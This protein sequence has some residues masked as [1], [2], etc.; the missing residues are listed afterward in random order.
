M[1]T[2]A[3]RIQRGPIPVA[4]ALG[5][6]K[7]IA[8]GLE[9]AHEKGV[10]HRDLKPANIKITADGKV[11]VLDF[12]L[13]KAYEATPAVDISNSPTLVSAASMPG[14]ILGTAA[15][16]SPEQARGKNVD[17]R[18]DVFSFGCVLYEMLT[19]Q[20][21]F[22]GKTV[23]D[24]LAAVL[25][26]DP[27]ATR[28]P[29]DVSITVRNILSRCLA[30]E[31]KQRWQ[32]I[33]DV[34]LEI[35]TVLNGGSAVT[36]QEAAPG[37]SGRLPWILVTALVL[38]A[39]IA[40]LFA[41][42]AVRH[43]RETSAPEMRV[44]IA[45]PPTTQPYQFALSP[46]GQSIVFIASSGALSQLWIRRL[47]R[48]DA[49]V[50]PGTEDARYPFWSPDSRSLAFF[51]GGKLKRID[52]AGGAA[53]SLSD[54]PSGYPGA[55]SSDGTILFSP[56]TGG[57]LSRVPASGGPAVPLNQKL[58]GTSQRFADFLPD[59]RNFVFEVAGGPEVSGIYLGSLDGSEP[60]RLSP[61]PSPVRYLLPNRIVFIRQG[62]LVAQE[63]DLSRRE[64][65]GNPETLANAVGFDAS[66]NITSAAFS[67]SADGRIA[68]RNGGGDRHQLLWFDRSG[69][70]DGN[71]G[72]PDSNGLTAPEISPDGRRVAVDRTVDRNRDV[73]LIDLFRG[74]TTRFTFDAA[75]DGYPVWSP[76]GNQIL[77]ESLRKSSNSFDLYVKPSSSAAP[78]QP[79]LELPG[80]QVPSDWSKD[81]RFVLYVDNSHGQH[82]I[83]TIPVTGNDR[84]P[85]VVTN[86]P[87]E[88]RTA[89]FSP[90]V[91]WVAYETNESGR[92]EIVVQSFPNPSGKWQVST[93]GGTQPRWSADGKELYFI[94]PD[95]K[96]MAAKIRTSGSSFEAASPEALF[97]TRISTAGV[98]DIYKQQYAVSRDGRFLIN[99]VE[100]SATAPITLILNW[101]P[102]P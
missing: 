14:M 97:Q 63:L 33:G 90:D 87:F 13:A 3:Q 40:M 25:A 66:T 36:A 9:A 89:A 80:G 84:K 83:M 82:D 52:V 20:Q 1:E 48:A 98:T 58:R 21:A 93:Q 101:R 27:D 94:A 54:A 11:K 56:R 16:M 102:K 81:G 24:V 96:L 42:P 57:P 62:T 19:G 23:S 53:V 99:S 17:H 46:D 91:H 7:Q 74:G 85:L 45:T 65:V 78:E 86:T 18:S 73:W 32:A 49:Q 43:L 47:D 2:L 55:W 59:G 77:F 72:E 10:V 31:T 30:K 70:P 100:E 34:R 26:R 6:A 69:K 28:I 71:A 92:F 61:E 5:I 37:R 75:T 41:I 50:L 68:Y 67:V 22:G 8:E 4:V 44:D 15:Y 12:G 60:K 29:A 35:E 51:A 95:R 38:M 39:L 88:E 64:L 79:L 76:D